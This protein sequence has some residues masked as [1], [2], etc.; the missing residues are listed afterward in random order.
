MVFRPLLIALQFLTVLPIHFDK[1][2]DAS[3]TVF[4][5]SGRPAH[6]RAVGS[7]AWIFSSALPQITATILLRLWVWLTSALHLDGLADSIDAWIGGRGDHDKTPAIMKAPA[8]V[9]WRSS[10][11]SWCC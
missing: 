1:A 4:L 6:R 9:P 3:A 8:A 7:M 5:P 11:W 2:P 10:V